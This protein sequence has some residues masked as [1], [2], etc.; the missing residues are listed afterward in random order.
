M[1][2]REHG[3]IA[4]P[5]G[6]V[7]ITIADD[8]VTAIMISDDPVPPGSAPLWREAAAQL[9]GWF[10]GTRQSF[11]LPLAAAATP[12]GN[13]LRR[14]M[15]AIGYGQTLSYG[16]LAALAGSSPRAIGQACARNPLPIVVP[17]HRVLSAGGRLGYYSAGAGP[18]TKAWLLAHE[19]R[20]SGE[21]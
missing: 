14:A 7:T 12:R 21:P 5:V 3:G 16:A 19:R 1:S 18:S 11:D 4:T 20:F 6:C 2:L 15:I 17:C 13:D 8:R 10:A 9:D